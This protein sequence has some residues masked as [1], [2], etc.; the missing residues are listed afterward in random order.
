MIKL[1]RGL[2]AATLGFLALGASASAQGYS[3]QGY[4]TPARPAQ[5][6]PASPSPPP[7]YQPQG[8]PPPAQASNPVCVRLESQLATI[9]SGASDPAHVAQIKQHEDAIAKQQADLDRT[10]AQAHKIGCAGEGFFALFSGLSPQ[11]GPLT[12]QIQQMRGNLDRLMNELEQLKSGGTDQQAQ[13]QGLI[14]QLAQNNCGAKYAEAARASGPAGFIEALLGGG[15]VHDVNGDGAPAGTYHTVCVRTCDGYYF[16]ISYSTVPSRFTD[17]ENTCKR[18][19]P[20]AEA[21]L[22]SFR[23]PGEQMEQAVS[24]GGQQYT[25]LPNAFR[26]RKE[27]VAGCSCRK[28]GESWADALRNTDDASTLESSDIV[29]TEK[30]AKALSQIPGAKPAPNGVVQPNNNSTAKPSSGTASTPVDPTKRKVRVV[31]PPFVSGQ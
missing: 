5:A 13:R 25:A 17:D 14:G 28:P 1:L 20:A 24:E 6:Y 16:P 27:L 2:S 11:C 21:T 3:P 8:A 10:L 29:V 12:S 4:P 9:D 15:T 19:C 30:N 23:N 18:M 31:G 7:G 26:Y 22:Y